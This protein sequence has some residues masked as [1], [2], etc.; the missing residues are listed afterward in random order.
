MSWCHANSFAQPLS[1]ESHTAQLQ[2]QVAALI[3]PTHSIDLLATKEYS[4][5]SLAAL[6][7]HLWPVL[8]PSSSG[9]GSPCDGIKNHGLW[10]TDFVELA[11]D[12]W[13]RTAGNTA[14]SSSLA[15]YHIMNIMLHGNL[16]VL[17]CFAHSNPGSETRDPEKSST[18]R[19]V[20]AWLHG[21]HYSIAHWHA[22]NLVMSVENAFIAPP[23]RAK[24]QDARLPLSLSLSSSTETARLPFEAPHVPYAVYFA[25][26][27]LW[28]G[29]MAKHKT[30]ASEVS[31]RAHLVRG[32]QILSQHRVHIAQLLA[33]VLEEIK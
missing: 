10:K 31:S 4:L 5:A 32:E 24:R 7:P 12:T 1:T 18:G 8:Y 14:N 25:T 19:E 23:T 9:T 15:V 13:L 29:T 26:L 2:R 3:G 16:A 27:V 11:G 6:T 30:S 22:E 20:H 33:A 17:Q 21:R 28:C